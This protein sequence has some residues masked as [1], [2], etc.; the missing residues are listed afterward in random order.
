MKSGW[1]IFKKK[2]AIVNS[3]SL[4]VMLVAST[5]AFAQVLPTGGVITSGNASINTAGNTMTINQSSPTA[6]VNWDSFS[7]GNAL[8]ETV[9]FANG[10]GATLNRVTGTAI[11]NIAGTLNGTGSVFLINPNGIIIDS[12]G[13]V[14]V[15]NDFIAST[16]GLN[17][18]NFLANQRNFNGSN[19]GNIEIKQGAMV[20]A[21][22]DV[23]FIGSNILN[24]G[25]VEAGRTLTLAAAGPNGAVNLNSNT[26]VSS[27]SGNANALAINNEGTLRATGLSTTNGRVILRASGGD[28]RNAGLIEAKSPTATGGNINI[29]ARNIDLASTSNISAQG[30][31]KNANIRIAADNNINLRGN[32][33]ATGTAQFFAAGSGS[34]LQNWE[35]NQG[36]IIADGAKVSAKSVQMWSGKTDANGVRADLSSANIEI[37]SSDSNGEFRSLNLHGFED[38][39]LNAVKGD[40]IVTD[41][42]TASVIAKNITIDDKALIQ[43]K[44]SDLI[45]S[46]GAFDGNG[47]FV[48]EGTNNFTRLLEGSGWKGEN[49]AM[50]VLDIKAFNGAPVVIDGCCHVKLS[51]SFNLDANGNPVRTNLTSENV[52]FAY[53]DSSASNSYLS[54]RAEG[55][56]DFDVNVENNALVSSSIIKIENM[57]NNIKYDVIAGAPIP[58]GKNLPTE[59]V[60]SDIIITGGKFDLADGI[61]KNS[62]SRVGTGTTS[63]DTSLKGSA[64]KFQTNKDGSVTLIS[65]ADANGNRP[66]I[67]EA[68]V[69]FAYGDNLNTYKNLTVEGFKDISLGSNLFANNAI[70]ASNNISLYAY[71][72]INVSGESINAGNNL[73]AIANNDMNIVNGSKVTA[74]NEN[75][76]VVDENSPFAVGAGGLTLSADSEI[77]GDK[78]GIYTAKQDQNSID[79]KISGQSFVPGLEYANSSTEQWLTF[80]QNGSNPQDPYKVYYKDSGSPALVVGAVDCET[81]PEQEGCAQ[82]MGS[83]MVREFTTALTDIEFNDTGNELASGESK[84]VRLTE[85]QALFTPNYVSSYAQMSTKERLA[86]ATALPFQL[87]GASLQGTQ[88][89]AELIPIPGFEAITTMITKPILGLNNVVN[90][91]SNI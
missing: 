78:V 51:S 23:A 49:G 12:T 66:D 16:Y 4:A 69:Q 82:A 56:N 7:I 29:Q 70:N 46:A 77:S 81:N 39:N 32:V 64:L 57:N 15:G 14:D 54:F 19:A 5:S 41:G 50:G 1:R 74:G 90:P 87:V 89:I 36:A 44:K 25:S 13:K 40:K 75:V 38:V 48:T 6:I 62:L 30:G 65:G 20:K 28:V 26:E 72:D 79:G 37:T 60:N 86:T 11:T 63:F 8:N 91:A 42:G 45:L 31:N 33:N 76:L 47:N 84:D 21:G 17:D 61:Y 80:Y 59:L 9:N 88:R 2:K 3:L 27:I 55:F 53:E 67:N 73:T 18:A 24:Q 58:T 43:T 34:N 83:P 10:A 22:R 35:T 68:L 85:R 52:R 71:N